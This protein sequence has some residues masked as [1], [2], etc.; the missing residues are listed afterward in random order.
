MGTEFHRLLLIQL[1]LV[2]V[3]T[4]VFLANFDFAHAVAAGFGVGIAVVNA[5]LLARCARRDAQA[6][7]RTPPQIMVAVYVCVIQ[8]FVLAA[9]L[10]AFGLGALQ[11]KPLALLI[12][13][14]VGQIAMVI[15][16]MQQLKQK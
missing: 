4:V 15:I 5:L 16:G 14:I 7:Q 8:R 1:L 3:A 9:L 2:G 13:F 12:G 10:F 6:L 11:L